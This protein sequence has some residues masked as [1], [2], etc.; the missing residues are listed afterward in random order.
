MTIEWKD[1]NKELPKDGQVVYVK[2]NKKGARRRRATFHDEHSVFSDDTFAS[3]YF[4]AVC[5]ENDFE[6]YDRN[7]EL[8]KITHWAYINEPTNIREE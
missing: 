7:N 4:C 5:R 6:G 3:L 1:V 8:I 2:S